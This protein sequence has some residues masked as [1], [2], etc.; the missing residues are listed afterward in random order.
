[1][2]RTKQIDSVMCHATGATN[3][4]VSARTC[5]PKTLTIHTRP[6][7]EHNKHHSNPKYLSSRVHLMPV[8]SKEVA[9]CRIV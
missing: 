4:L 8:D 6:Q 2:M 9:V 3:F 7:Q 5:T 1:M